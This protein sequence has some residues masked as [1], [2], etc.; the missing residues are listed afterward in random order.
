[1]VHGEVEPHDATVAPAHDVAA[2]H[3]EPR[4]ESGHV[5]GHGVVGERPG[6]VAR[7][8]LRAGVG[9]NEPE[10]RLEERNLSGELVAIADAAVEQDEH[11]TAP[12]VLVVEAKAAQGDDVPVD[13]EWRARGQG[14]AVGRRDERQAEAERAEPCPRGGHR[15]QCRTPCSSR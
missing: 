15:T 3:A 13:R 9:D 5:I 11:R 14:R 1:M 7:A 12:A 10:A 2:A 8:T 4:Q 6:A